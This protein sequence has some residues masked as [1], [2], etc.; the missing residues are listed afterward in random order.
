MKLTRFMHI[1]VVA[2]IVLAALG[3]SYSPVAA[4]DVPAID[5]PEYVPGQLIVGFRGESVPPNFLSNLKT[6]LPTSSQPRLLK[7]T[8]GSALVGFSASANMQEIAARVSRMSGVRYAEPNYILALNLP[9]SDH[10]RTGETEY[11]IRPVSAEVDITQTP[12][13]RPGDPR[14]NRID[15]ASLETRSATFTD[16]KSFVAVPVDTVKSM[17]VNT[18][19]RA[20][21][22]YPNDAYLWWNGGPWTT[23][24]AEIV[25]PNT[26]VSKNVCVVDTGVDYNHKDLTTAFVLKGYDFV[27]DDL[28]PMDDNG[29]GT[30]V[31]GIIT[32]RPNNAIGIV[33]AAPTA[34]V[35][36]VKV[37]NSQGWGTTYNI[38]RGIRSCADRT[39]VS[40]L[41]L[42]LGSYTN[43]QVLY[44]AVNYAVNA[45]GKLLVA[46]AG[47][48]NVSAKLYP[49]AYS[50]TL[51]FPE[52]EN[53]VISVAASGTYYQPDPWDNPNW[54][55]VDY[56]CKADYSNYG[57]WVTIVA[58]GTS[59][60]STTPWDRSFWLNEMYGV[61]M[62]YSWMD[63]T[64]MASPY[65]AAAAARGWGYAPTSFNW[66]VGEALRY[67]APFG[68]G[69][70]GDESCW[71]Y[72]QWDEPMVNVAAM[73]DRGA[74][75]G[76]VRDALTGLPLSGAQ[77]QA[78]KSGVLVGSSVTAPDTWKADPSEPDPTRIYL[79]FNAGADVLNL[80][81]SMNTYSFKAS[82]TNY[83][84]S[85]Q[86]VFSH[87]G[88]NDVWPGSYTYLSTAAIPPKSVNFD[89]S[90]GW[91]SWYRG[92]LGTPYLDGLEDLDLNVSLP[93]YPNVADI[94]QPDNFVVGPEGNSFNGIGGVNPEGTMVA[95]P[96]AHRKRDGGGVDW[97]NFETT[98]ISSRKAHGSLAANTAVPYYPGDYVAWVT[99]WG[100][101]V[102]HDAD[103]CGDNYGADFD[104]TYDNT[105]GGTG[106]PGIPVMG[107]YLEPYIYVWKD[108]LIKSFI[109]MDD[110]Y[111]PESACNSHWWQAMKVTSGTVGVPSYAFIDDCATDPWWPAYVDPAG[112]EDGD[113]LPNGWEI[114]GYDANADGI[115]DIDLP[116]LGANYQHKDIFV[117]MDY[118]Y[119]DTA[120]YGLA[121][122]QAVLDEIVAVFAS[123][124][125]SNP[126]GVDGINIHLDLDNQV[127]YD[128]DLNN[129]YTEFYN[130]KAANFDP[131]R[132]AVYHYMIWADRYSGGTSSGLSFGIPATDFIV[133][134]GGWNSGT[135][136]TDNQKIGTFIHELGHNLNLTH[137]G[138]DHTNYKPNYL[139]VM[140][141]RFQTSGVYRDGSW[142]NFDYQR[143]YLPALDEMDLDETAGLN[144]VDAST[145]GTYHTCWNSGSWVFSANANGP[146]D[147]DCDTDDT[148][149]SVAADIN[150]DGYVEALGSQDNW[151]SIVFH[152]GG[153][154]GSG[155]SP[156]A[157][158]AFIQDNYVDPQL[159]ELT[160]EEQLELDAHT[161]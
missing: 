2:S 126:D 83:T 82:M 143:F 34:K 116:A 103:G 145:Y 62:R 18:S 54:W 152:G 125:V 70:P 80:P 49:A 63:G 102:D 55:E 154:I 52:F 95:F 51:A 19:P 112:D 109:N 158:M 92:D 48:D 74:A 121:P 151:A 15:P 117:E 134:L 141:Y 71:P 159:D 12:A 58:P 39:D 140:N 50:D 108:G 88:A 85:P 132:T 89:V 107:P 128:N 17:R 16:G 138:S 97:I 23:V 161:P 10:Q 35:V 106:T 119:R 73:M 60:F 22:V 113:G 148:E 20:R 110:G 26:T 14:L 122:S 31:A 133:T 160:Y 91:F 56:W 131:T 21:G 114:N 33:G 32:A 40:V 127:A 147:W 94:A 41:N 27:N 43:H 45:K 142:G 129:V 153:V 67:M 124:P 11:I 7:S 100:Q 99:D 93:G 87:R 137:G 84:A 44:D 64:S 75:F 105:C 61:D 9:E 150:Y 68:L 86:N 4:Q 78:Y 81:V 77:I 149:T 66:Q 96:F 90:L 65:V 157:L 136:G 115:V 38:A 69:D 28:D 29:H 101:T 24:G 123:A 130:L 98:A 25:W 36:A 120:T 76:S 30:H 6:A 53:K 111:D 139:S 42:S 79:G 104:S 13:Y 1:L 59:V 146:I 3:I 46:A 5:E 72:A 57:D 135:G 156:Q 144:S 47:N 118:M 155:M 37:L 8:T